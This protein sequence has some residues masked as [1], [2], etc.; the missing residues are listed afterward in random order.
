M[1]AGRIRFFHHGLRAARGRGHL[2]RADR[3]RCLRHHPHSRL[4]GHRRVVVRAAG[5][6]L[7]PPADADGQRPVLFAAGVLLRPRPDADRVPGP[8]RAVW[9]GD[10]RRVGRRRVADDGERAGEVARR[11]VR[12]AAGGISQRLHAGVAALSRAAVAGLARDVHGRRDPGAAGA[13]YP[14]HRAGKPGLAGAHPVRNARSASGR[15]CAS[16]RG[17]WD[18]P[19]S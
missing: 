5:R 6:P 12:P 11:G 3:Q 16:T 8:A 7:R 10:G 13:V 9:R 2:R 4:P 15:C 17:W 14:P 18:S 1:D 19:P